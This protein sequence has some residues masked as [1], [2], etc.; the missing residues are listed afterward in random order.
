MTHTPKANPPTDRSRKISTG[1][2]DS[3]GKP[4]PEWMQKFVQGALENLHNLKVHPNLA[5]KP[6]Q[7]P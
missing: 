3:N 6:P 5:K 2:L 1:A 7:K 4:M